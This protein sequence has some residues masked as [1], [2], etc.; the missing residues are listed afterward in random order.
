MI[1]RICKV[2]SLGMAIS[3]TTAAYCGSL[4]LDVSGKLGHRWSTMKEKGADD[5]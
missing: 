3:F 2:L 5:P 1:R 4:N